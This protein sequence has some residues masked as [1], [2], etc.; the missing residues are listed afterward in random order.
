MSQGPSP[1]ARAGLLL[2][3]VAVVGVLI[4]LG[5]ESSLYGG[6]VDLVELPTGAAD[7][8][9]QS[10]RWYSGPS[11]EERAIILRATAGL[12]PYKDAV[13]QAL[14][15]DFLDPGSRIAAAWFMTR[16]TPE[17][18][19][20]YYRGTLLDA[21]LPI[22]QHRYG[23]NAGYVGYMTPHTEEMHMVSALAQGGET[24][25]FISAGQV[26]SFVEHQGQVPQ[27]LPLPR[28]V[29]KP[30]VLTFRQEG[31]VRY[32][33]VAELE[34]GQV[35]ELK[36]FFRR[37]FEAQGWKIDD[38]SERGTQEM[39]LMVSRGGSRATAMAQRQGVGVR[40]YLSLEQQDP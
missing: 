9:P 18:V 25:V 8:I 7:D 16:D 4:G 17:Q 30:M 13:P 5:L 14:A 1:L 33:V 10:P 20:G 6:E 24:A 19:L 35:V 12:P 34:E 27:G 40:L 2:F 28:G 21:G 39:Q 23:E 29:R 32:S 36:D 22:V 37:A 31:R 38:V 11:P 26:G 15:A 3:S